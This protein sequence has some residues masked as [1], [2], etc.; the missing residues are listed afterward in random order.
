MPAFVINDLID[1]A[2]VY[3]DDDH[4]EDGDGGALHTPES[5]LNFANVEY[6][7]LYRKWVRAGLVP[8]T[9]VDT[10]LISGSADLSTSGFPVMAVIGVARDYGGGSVRVLTPAQSPLGVSP[11]W[12]TSSTGEG[13]YWYAAGGITGAPLTV[14][15]EPLDTSGSYFVRWMPGPPT[16]TDPTSTLDVP[17]GGDERLV[18]GMARRAKLKEGVVSNLLE[19]LIAD[20][21]AQ[22]NFQAFSQLGGDGPRVRRVQD[23]G[24]RFQQTDFPQPMYWRWF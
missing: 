13:E 20:E 7:H 1:R 10:A 12:G 18:L 2:R 23:T 5:W 11:F 24:T 19:R 17:F 21:D 22:L 9:L 15:I 8:P 3:L 14:K 16:P 4:D 6:R